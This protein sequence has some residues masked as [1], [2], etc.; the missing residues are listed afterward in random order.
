M[1]GDKEIPCNHG[2]AQTRPKQTAGHTCLGRHRGLCLA[3]DPPR[4]SHLLRHFVGSSAIVRPE[5]KH[6]RSVSPNTHL[7][8][9]SCQLAMLWKG[10]TQC[11]QNADTAAGRPCKWKPD[12]SLFTYLTRVSLTYFLADVLRE[13]THVIMHFEGIN[14]FSLSQKKE[15]SQHMFTVFYWKKGKK[16]P[17]TNHPALN[18]YSAGDQCS[19][20]TIL[21][22]EPQKCSKGV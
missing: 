2:D 1:P 14:L 22:Y 3:H 5:K 18:T 8:S 20:E 16:P 19:C 6:L 9:G 17:Q 15:H 11:M 7:S 4:Q 10:K 12:L 13:Q 21:L